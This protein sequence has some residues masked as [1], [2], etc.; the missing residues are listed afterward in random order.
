MHSPLVIVVY[1]LYLFSTL[2]N[3]RYDIIVDATNSPAS[4][5]ML[6]DCC[7]LLQKVIV[8]CSE[9]IRICCVNLIFW[10]Q[11]T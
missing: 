1:I 11:Y 8:C 3:H 10:E 2:N 6:N 9:N 4:R 5:Y 7:V